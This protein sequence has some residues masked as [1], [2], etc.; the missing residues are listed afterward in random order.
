MAGLAFVVLIMTT[1]H[2]SAKLPGNIKEKD[3]LLPGPWGYMACLRAT[4]RGHRQ[5]EKEEAWTW[6]FVCIRVPKMKCL[7]FT[8]SLFV[9]EFKA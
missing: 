4:Q 3:L 9:G 2:I 8:G 7:G 6:G 1:G 5:R